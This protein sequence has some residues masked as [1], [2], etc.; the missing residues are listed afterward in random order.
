MEPS[1]PMF[2]PP[3]PIRQIERH[4]IKPGHIIR[5]LDN[6]SLSHLGAVV[7]NK[8]NQLLYF[9][10][11]DNKYPVFSKITEEVPIEKLGHINQH[12]YQHLKKSLLRYYWKNQHNIQ[13]KHIMKPLLNFAFI[14][15]IPLCPNPTSEEDEADSL[16][17]QNK[18]MNLEVGNQVRIK[19]P[20]K[21]SLN[22]LDNQIV[23][24]VHSMDN[25]VVIMKPGKQPAE[26]KFYNLFQ[27]TYPGGYAGV[28]SID[29]INEYANNHL[30]Q[31]VIS[32][33]QNVGSCP[34]G[35]V[36]HNGQIYS[37]NPRSFQAKGI[38]NNLS[39]IYDVK[40][41]T[42]H[43]IDDIDDFVFKDN[44][45]S[46]GGGKTPPK[47]INPKFAGDED[48]VPE[49]VEDTTPET[50]YN[51][52]EDKK[53]NSP[54][55]DDSSDEEEVPI[56]PVLLAPKPEE[57][58]SAVNDDNVTIINENDDEE[59]DN[60]NNIKEDDE[61]DIKGMK[62]EKEPEE[63][64][65]ENATIEEEDKDEEKDKKDDKET[66]EE[67]DDEDDEDDEEDEDDKEDD[68]END[69]D[70]KEEEDKEE[71]L[72]TVKKES[73][74]KGKMTEEFSDFDFNLDIQDVPIEIGKEVVYKVKRVLIP[75]EKKEYRE[76]LQ[77]AEIYKVLIDEIPKEARKPTIIRRLNKVANRIMNLI[78]DYT[79]EEDRKVITLG[80][81]Y[82][83]LLEA[84]NNNDY[85]SKFLIP[86]VLD[87]K[88][89][90]LDDDTDVNLYDEKSNYLIRD[91]HEE[92]Q[93]INQ[94]ILSD[95]YKNQLINL[96]SWDRN[97][98]N[99]TLPYLYNDSQVYIT[100]DINRVA[101]GIKKE[102]LPYANYDT[103]VFRACYKPFVC[104][105]YG[106]QQVDIDT[107]IVLSPDFRYLPKLVRNI[108][109]EEE[110]NKQSNMLVAT[111]PAVTEISHG[112]RLN[113][114]G[115]VS[116]PPQF[117]RHKSFVNPYHL[118]TYAPY[119]IQILN[120]LYQKYVDDKKVEFV[121]LDEKTNPMDVLKSKQSNKIVYYLFQQKL[122]WSKYD[123]LR[124][125]VPRT[126]DVLR[127]EK[128]LVKQIHNTNQLSDL[129][130][131]YNIN[132][133]QQVVYQDIKPVL[134][135]MKE[136]NKE[137]SNHWSDIHHQYRK[138]R[139]KYSKPQP[140]Q[141]DDFGLIDDALLDELKPFY[142]DPPNKDY[143]CDNRSS[144]LHWVRKQA[145]NGLLAYMFLLRKSLK[146]LDHRLI[147]SQLLK[148]L[149]QVNH[150]RLEAKDKF[151]NDQDIHKYFKK[152]VAEE[153]KKLEELK[154]SMA[155]GGKTTIKKCVDKEG[156]ETYMPIV[157]SY[158]TK[159]Q[160]EAD[161]YTKVKKDDGVMI[162]EGNYALQGDTIYRRSI[163]DTGEYWK[164]MSVTIVYE[165][166][167]GN[168]QTSQNK[169][170]T[171]TVV[172]HQNK[173]MGDL[174]GNVDDN[175][176]QMATP[177]GPILP[178]RLVRLYKRYMSCN[179]QMKQIQAEIKFWKKLPSML[180]EIEE[181]IKVYQRKVIL[182]HNQLQHIRNN[183]K[184]EQRRIDEEVKKFK[185]EI[186]D[187]I[188]FKA[189]EYIYGLPNITEIQK[190]SLINNVIQKFILIED[191]ETRIDVI[192]DEPDKNWSHCNI[193][194]Q[195]LY[196]NHYLYALNMATESDQINLS[197]VKDIFGEEVD[198]AFYCHI[199]GEHI[200]SSEAL[201]IEKFVRVYGKGN[202]RMVAR[203]V[204]DDEDEILE[205]NVIEDFMD[206]IDNIDNSL[207]KSDMK[208]F[209]DT[210]Q[211]ICQLM[212]IDL[213]YE[214]ET[215]MVS[216]IQSNPFTGREYLMESIKRTGK[217]NNNLQLQNLTERQFKK[218]S[219]YDIA[220]RL[221]FVIQTSDIE[222]SVNNP[223]CIG[224]LDGYPLVNNESDTG[225]IR[226]LACILDKL[227]YDVD[228][229][230]MER[231][232]NSIKILFGRIKK[233]F[234]EDEYIQNKYKNFIQ[235]RGR[236]IIQTDNFR[237]HTTNIWSQF[238]PNLNTAEVD[239]KP[240]VHYTASLINNINGKNIH[241][242]L[243]TIN[244]NQLWYSSKI[245]E[246][247]A[248]YIDKDTP[249]FT[250][251]LQPLYNSCCKQPLSKDYTYFTGFAN[252]E[253]FHK[254]LTSMDFQK[255]SILRHLKTPTISMN[256]QPVS[257]PSGGGD[258][259]TLE[260]KLH[261]AIFDNESYSIDSKLPDDMKQTLLERYVDT[262]MHIG[263]R[264]TFNEYDIC[265][266]TGK[267]KNEILERK[268]NDAEI[269]H[270]LKKVRLAQSVNII[271]EKYPE[272][273]STQAIKDQLNKF[274]DSNFELKND[275][276]LQKF[277][278]G[279]Y[280]AW[281][282]KKSKQQ[283]YQ[284]WVILNNQIS[285][286][287]DY[288]N[289]NLHYLATDKDLKDI[290][291]NIGFY[292]QIYKENFDR[293]GRQPANIIRLKTREANIKKY[294]NT[295]FKIMISRIKNQ[296]F[297]IIEGMGDA[298]KFVINYKS[299]Q[300]MFHRIL[301]KINGHVRNIDSIFG[302]QDTYF[303]Y[304]EST[305]FLHYVFMKTISS[306]FSIHDTG[307]IK[308]AVMDETIDTSDVISSSEMS[309]SES[310]VAGTNYI[311]GIQ[312]KQ[313]EESKVLADFIFN[314]L[315][316][317]REDEKTY[318]EL[319]QEFI[320]RTIE[321]ERRKSL[322]KHLELFQVMEE[323][324]KREEKQII[325]AKI[326]INGAHRLRYEKLYGLYTGEEEDDTGVK[327]NPNA[328]GYQNEELLREHQLNRESIMEE[329][330]GMI[331]DDEVGLEDDLF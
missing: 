31:N 62:Y 10:N 206:K 218:N 322:K 54:N 325:Q 319:T 174:M 27:Q 229:K 170:S 20:Q 265:I 302:I 132:Y 87:K 212:S 17:R 108:Y 131:R 194:Q 40:D 152:N 117:D 102:M 44:I 264:R 45:H 123:Y 90:F 226:Y 101:D 241:K 209:L 237:K 59:E 86:I 276:F 55:E 199:C 201:A 145:D 160:L 125:L 223:E 191:E 188:H 300:K 284:N 167:H 21:S 175:T 282:E 275:K 203:A 247:L 29:M 60:I 228:W 150:D 254:Q 234:E 326:N 303:S 245:M 56:N 231:E 166:K 289:D 110:E 14:D 316:K 57:S 153:E 215:E 35:E 240:P 169:M 143:S 8:P 136:N 161:N 279:L 238:L 185:P 12:E 155:G 318:D 181:D 273:Q 280:K 6:T 11:V 124:R 260:D 250:H 72:E 121:D 103:T 85:R 204:L 52:K 138:N 130:S 67:D 26:N 224:R 115:Y 137:L 32:Q 74:I 118:D 178:R 49:K 180:K 197:K 58:P 159:E 253:E 299:Q 317:I 274:I 294:V 327:I 255:N 91:F 214:H 83:P 30:D 133:N 46:G 98:M 301:K 291:D 135:Q 329:Q 99:K 244:N 88:K 320:L 296:Q 79:H 139:D 127:F 263:K 151:E 331:D 328:E 252:F 200:I 246:K 193:C 51:S 111:T 7:D 3:T 187:C 15:G 235:N 38:H 173:M 129:L 283:V 113:I 71:E 183:R 239:W 77:R 190:Y 267:T 306:L 154:L 47:A 312:F 198:G 262:G 330:G 34:A 310:S 43:L 216:Y 146:N 295:Y 65:L 232:T 156:K 64:M 119:K 19:C 307:H 221:F 89:I 297:D 68:K 324:G 93:E 109:Q 76:S 1:I 184:E 196:C 61:M 272:V 97:L 179:E 112:E 168:I 105:T 210:F 313:T 144:R 106:H 81:D 309:S 249:S 28:S 18:T 205:I 285:A 227:K 140:S 207:V 147:I 116:L 290:L 189:T 292:R 304:E 148:D 37:V 288:I 311:K 48:D 219:L 157:K 120:E 126:P 287:I 277:M 257:L 82:R 256:Y 73:D 268:Y 33:L 114:V 261:V 5:V 298:W 134:K 22:F 172:E 50:F 211:K 141:E 202:Q 286:E 225:G 66:D 230:F 171:E 107:H 259:Y 213:S 164:P 165:D 182:E 186:R 84:Y 75:D 270:I 222:Y 236:V 220:V 271:Q 100:D 4:E 208:Y 80:E 163:N 195:K 315:M 41:D 242:F 24:V 96:D 278:A 177:M 323:A 158:E 305:S 53:N 314:V 269:H 176:C 128:K 25:G 149:R 16:I 36:V 217:V 42:I 13:Q 70:D 78:K 63:D 9:K 308:N 321:S 233:S 162:E 104:N 142:G 39:G 258:S 281:D 94:V 2:Q 266:V 251:D 192:H 95:N 23:D 293:I 92:M 243:S 122:K 248:D 69:E